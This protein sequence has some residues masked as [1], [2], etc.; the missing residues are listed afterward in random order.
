MMKKVDIIAATMRH[1]FES[2]AKTIEWTGPKSSYA[3]YLLTTMEGK[4]SHLNSDA[5]VRTSVDLQQLGSKCCPVCH[6]DYP[7]EMAMIELQSGSYT[8]VCCAVQRA[9]GNTV[10]GYP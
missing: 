3:E 10:R 2:D 1:A 7:D 5:E 9:I 4:F 6:D 8:W